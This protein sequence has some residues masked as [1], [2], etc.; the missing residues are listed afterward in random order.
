MY[1]IFIGEI[2]I[3][4]ET[5]LI[6]PEGERITVKYDA[7][8]ETDKVYTVYIGARNEPEPE[9]ETETDSDVDGDETA[10]PESESAAPET[11]AN[12]PDDEETAEEEESK[13]CYFY[14]FNESTVVYNGDGETIDKI[15]SYLT[16]TPKTES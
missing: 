8:G 16:Y 7:D 10:A 2:L 5:Y 9:A 6:S 11:D 1:F 15:F 3:F 4:T 13:Y 12:T 14:T